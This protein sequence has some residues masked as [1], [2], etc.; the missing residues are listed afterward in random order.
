MCFGSERIYS[1][2]E[3]QTAIV[4]E[5]LGIL[6][7]FPGHPNICLIGE[8]FH[9]QHRRTSGKWKQDVFSLLMWPL[10]KIKKIQS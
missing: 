5:L 1:F 3:K 8:Q 10:E 4:E 6:R 9:L 2:S 7:W